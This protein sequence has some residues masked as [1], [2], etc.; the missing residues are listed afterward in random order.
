MEKA[1]S[2]TQGT[3]WGRPGHWDEACSGHISSAFNPCTERFSFKEFRFWMIK[4]ENEIWLLSNLANSSKALSPHPEKL[5][6]GCEKGITT[7]AL[8]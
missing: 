1:L 4:R 3:I 5:G 2:T 7:S 8:T 6:T